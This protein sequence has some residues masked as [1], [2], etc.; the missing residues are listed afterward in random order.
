MRSVTC[1]VTFSLLAFFAAVSV[2]QDLNSADAH[3]ISERPTETGEATVIHVSLYVIDI[4][5]I[6]D[7][8]QEFSLDMFVNVAWR[9]SRLGLPADKRSGESRTLPLSEVWSPRALIVNDRGISPQLPMIVEVDDLGNVQYRQRLSGELA[10]DFELH[11]FPFDTQRLPIDIVSYQYSPEN[12]RFESK[13]VGSR[14]EGDFSAE[15]WRFRIL[16]PEL[17]EFSIPAA[18]I[19][20]PRL[21]YV[22]EAQRVSRFYLLTMFLPVSL[23]VFMSWTAFWLQPDLVPSRVGI[24]T[25]SIF[26]LIAFGY[27][28]RASLPHISYMTRADIFVTGCMLLVFLALGAAVLGSRWASADEMQRALRVNAITRWLYIALFGVVAVSTMVL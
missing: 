2:A 27:S 12:V 3:L 14:D 25:A 8:G 5:S 15:G 20:R 21:T 10:V 16:E 4:A 6:D 7:A 17:G 11:E 9:D 1:F 22:I 26:S 13:I 19:V 23:I 18:G 28:I 24:S